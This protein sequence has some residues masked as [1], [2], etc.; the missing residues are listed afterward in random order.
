LA[1]DDFG[2]G[3]SSLSY[4]EKLPFDTV[5]IDIAF[6]RK[7]TNLKVKLPILKGIISIANG[8]GLDVVAEGVENET[9]LNYLKA[10]GCHLVQG[11]YFNPSFSEQELLRQLLNQ[12]VTK[13]RKPVALNVAF[14][15]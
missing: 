6:I 3:H 9:Q 14:N 1:I 12:D 13:S 15:A 8:M 10:H 2:T 4:L 5:K 11:Y 7:I